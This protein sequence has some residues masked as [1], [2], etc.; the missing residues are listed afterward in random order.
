MRIYELTEDATLYFG[1]VV[2]GEAYQA[3]IPRGLDPA[4]ILRL[5]RVR[6]L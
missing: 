3:L 4:S 6:P 2:G 1:R 5:V